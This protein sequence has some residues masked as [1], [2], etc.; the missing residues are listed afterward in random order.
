MGESESDSSDPSDMSDSPE[1]GLIRLRRT[2]QNAM[3]RDFRIPTQKV[4]I[5]K[6]PPICDA[7]PNEKI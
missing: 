4:A 7:L 6:S 1:S 3:G 5:W 2:N